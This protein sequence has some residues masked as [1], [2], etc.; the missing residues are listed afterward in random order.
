MVALF[1]F[2]IA[3]HPLASPWL[4]K[5]P[6]ETVAV[7]GYLEGFGTS[8][9][10]KDYERLTGNPVLPEAPNVVLLGDS[11]VEALQ[12]SDS[13]TAGAVLE[14]LSRSSGQ[15]VNV[16][17][18]GWGSA[19]GPWYALEAPNILERHMPARVAVVLNN[20]DIK[21]QTLHGFVHIK[22]LEGSPQVVD[23]RRARPD[24]WKF[25]LYG[26]ILSRSSL[27]YQLYLAYRLMQF[28]T[29]E[30]LDPM[31]PGEVAPD[32]NAL[33]R[34]NVRLLKSAY[35]ERLLLIYDA[36]LRG[37]GTAIEAEFE[38]PLLKICR[39]EAVQCASTRA[40]LIR[41]RVNHQRFSRGFSNTNP[42]EGHWN[43]VG[44]QIVAEVIWRQLQS[45]QLKAF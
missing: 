17:Q 43:R 22:S 34:A 11:H 7:R 13:E 38:E 35:G 14:R 21:Y 4:R 40:A 18:Y 15:P 36:E 12:V 19:S 41:D 6:T 9:F 24:T 45:P 30:D 29:M 10:T 2:E 44:H 42:G 27:A 8:H 37:V 39:E 16:H 31:P 33:L 32:T 25:R 3:L 5:P 26:P 28:S 20:E 23:E 1:L